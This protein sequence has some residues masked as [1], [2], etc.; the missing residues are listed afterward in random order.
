[1][2]K[3]NVPL[4]EPLSNDT[5][6]MHAK[7]YEFTMHRKVDIDLS[8]LSFYKLCRLNKQKLRITSYKKDV[9]LHEWILEKNIS[10]FSKL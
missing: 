2:H 3:L 9:V 6:S 4:G 5:G 1:M 10:H 8:L 7:F